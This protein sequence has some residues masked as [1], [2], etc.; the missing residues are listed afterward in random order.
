[1]AKMLA[2]SCVTTQPC[3]ETPGSDQVVE[4]PSLRVETGGRLI[5]EGMS[6]EGSGPR[7]PAR[8]H[9]AAQPR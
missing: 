1:M 9:P 8:L 5:Q 3:R 2:S 4:A 6:V 7:N